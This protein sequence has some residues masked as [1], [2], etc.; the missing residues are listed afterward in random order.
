LGV[1]LSPIVAVVRRSRGSA[2]VRERSFGGFIS[3]FIAES[4][5]DLY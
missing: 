2:K 3:G 1:L 4:V 5:V